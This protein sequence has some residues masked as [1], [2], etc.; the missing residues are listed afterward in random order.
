MGRSRCSSCSRCSSV[1]RALMASREASEA[2]VL[3]KRVAGESGPKAA[4]HLGPSTPQDR[5]EDFSLMAPEPNPKG[6]FTCVELPAVRKLRYHENAIGLFQLR[7]WKLRSSAIHNMSTKLGSCQ[8]HVLH[9]NCLDNMCTKGR[10]VMFHH[11]GRC[12]H[13]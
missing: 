4:T 11:Q 10:D 3:L 13:W 9:V 12:G 7:A 2:A 1:T 5:R 8:N 6:K